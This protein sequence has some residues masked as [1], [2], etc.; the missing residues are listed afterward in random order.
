MRFFFFVSLSNVTGE[1]F[2]FRFTAIRSE[3][4]PKHLKTVGKISSEPFFFRTVAAYKNVW[5]GA[6]VLIGD[7]PV[8]E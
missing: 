2:V 4:R 3:I 7:L 6:H 5:H 8:V 1:A